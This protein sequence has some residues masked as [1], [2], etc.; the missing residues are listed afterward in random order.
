MARISIKGPASEAEAAAVS[1]A[2][3][4]FL[5]DTSVAPAPA[6]TGMNP[7]LRAA[8]IEGVSAKASFG[9]SDPRDLH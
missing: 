9:S 4:R 6:D 7:W 1:A 5:A 8:L 3:E 2:I